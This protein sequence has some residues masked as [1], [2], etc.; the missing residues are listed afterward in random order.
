MID[1]IHRLKQ[2]FGTRA[3]PTAELELS[4]MQARM[5]GSP[6]KGVKTISVVLN[7]TRIYCAFTSAAYMQRGLEMAKAYAKVRLAQG[8]PLAENSLH[9][10]NLAAMEVNQNAALILTFYVISLLGR[11]ESLKCQKAELLL[12][13]LTPVTKMWVCKIT[14]GALSE[15]MEAMGGQGYMEDVGLTKLYRD[16]QVNSIWEGTTNIMGLDVIRIL[17]KDFENT[18]N[19]YKKVIFHFLTSLA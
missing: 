14:L 7:I 16:A 19:T 5:L 10:R 15:C 6:G 9:M 3:V 18:W 4:G 11:Q 8:K 1:R 13:F 2:K 17:S 12:R